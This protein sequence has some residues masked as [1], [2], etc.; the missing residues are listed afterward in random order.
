MKP[1]IER[2]MQE[3]SEKG[4]PVMHP[5]FYDFPKDE[6]SWIILYI[7]IGWKCILC[8]MKHHGIH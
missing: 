7:L 6:E 4:T 5:L 2:L 1:Y 8:H 3:A